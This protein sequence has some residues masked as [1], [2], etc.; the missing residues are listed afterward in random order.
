MATEPIAIVG[1]GCRFPGGAQTP[2]EYWRVL[3]AAVPTASEVP[4]ERGWSLADFHD[5]DPEAPGRTI[6]ARANFLGPVDGFDSGFFGLTPREAQAIDPQHRL[7]LEVAWEAL[8]RA[9]QSPDRL[10]G[11]RTSV[12]VGVVSRDYLD[13]QFQADPARL[14]P[15]TATGGI[16]SLLAARLSHLLDLRSLAVSVDGA[17]SS[18]LLAVHYAV[19]ALRAGEC[20][21]A[22]AG[23]VNLI[24]LPEGSVILSQMRALSPDGRSK[25]FAASADG[26]GRAEGCGIVV[27]KRLSDAQADGD[28]VLA[29]VRGSAVNQDGRSSGVTVPNRWAQQEVIRAAL[30]DGGVT[31]RAV[32]YVEVHGTGTPL[33]DPIEVA[34]LGAVLSPGR[35]PG[36]PLILGAA[37]AVVG[38]A[39][40]AA[41]AAGL[42]KAVLCLAN[43]MIPAQPDDGPLNPALDL[44][45]IPA[46]VPFTAVPWPRRAEPRFA[47]VS[48]FGFSGTNVHVVLE[49]APPEPPPADAGPQRPA[50]LLALSA[51]GE[52]P[53]RELAGRL[54]A[55]LTGQVPLADV[56]HSVNA[57]RR[58][59]PY[60]AAVTARDPGQL[61]GA[62]QA[63]AEGRQAADAVVGTAPAMPPRL[64]F[65][66]AGQGGAAVGMG[67]AL[68]ETQPTF[69]AATEELATVARDEHG[70][71]ILDVLYPRDPGRDGEPIVDTELAQPA[72]FVIEAAL[73]RLWRSWGAEPA[74]VLGHSVGEYPAACL[75]GALAWNDGLRL[76]IERG[77]LMG[78][79]P[80]GG[81]MLAVLGSAAAAAA[82]A[83]GYP[84]V[85]VAAVNGPGETVLSG[86]LADLAVIRTELARAAIACRPLRVSH[87]FHSPLMEP[88]LD[89]FEMLAATLRLR[90]PELPLVSN[91]TGEVVRPGELADGHRWRR[92]LRE[93]VLFG[94]G[95]RALLGR[96]CTVFVEIGPDAALS[97]IG[98][99][100]EPGAA[101]LP[102]LRGRRHDWDQMLDTLA[103]LYAHGVP[104]NWTEFDRDYPR[105]RRPLPTY[106]FQRRRTWLDGIGRPAAAHGG[107]P[108]RRIDSPL[109]QAQ[110][111]TVL[112]LTRQPELVDTAGLVHVGYYA[113]LLAQAGRQAGLAGR[114]V[115]TDLTISHALVLRPGTERRVQTIIEPG[116]PQAA[117]GRIASLDEGRWTTHAEATLA[118]A[119]NG[120]PPSPP[121]A[122]LTGGFPETM[123]GT[124]F[125]RRLSERRGIV[126]GPSVALIESVWRRDG[127]ALARLAAAPPSGLGFGRGVFDACVQLGYAALPAGDEDDS[128]YLLARIARLELGEPACGRLWCH[129]E[130]ATV[131]P[132]G[133]ARTGRFALTD[134]SGIVVALAEGVTLRRTR[135][136]V[137]AGLGAVPPPAGPCATDG[138]LAREV[139]ALPAAAAQDLLRQ[140][141]ADRLAQALGLPSAELPQDQP[142]TSLG[143]D[144]LMSM[145]VRN[146]LLARLGITLPLERLLDGASVGELA[147]EL[148]VATAA[149]APPPKQEVEHGVI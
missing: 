12:F 7:V 59:W 18:A 101:W 57:G 115:I 27:L 86:P 51:R 83:A 20:D 77:R 95:L 35:P 21:L 30:R 56:C 131:R 132:S 4:A 50:H 108:G 2:E 41:G 143:I 76:T 139:R 125:Y 19:R 28:T 53:L 78:S 99:R 17:C 33:G 67:R 133:S 120:P 89:E 106:P 48:A 141:L 75:A 65:L 105:R 79:L 15:Y 129:A 128:L 64:A 130:L 39:E 111:E 93:P 134:D 149:A 52:E 70:L 16:S 84:N 87:A 110:F 137:V 112:G 58:H 147:A 96:G 11:G 25:T 3:E 104:V 24:L 116:L 126:L 73:A 63:L 90:E 82:A 37:K 91:L 81:G 138:T 121:P 109:P 49:E 23:G 97:G 136:E 146:A 5:P 140:E 98:M 29:L 100:A 36:R 74:A 34:A 148:A 54:A 31:P 142:L 9:A 123:N 8:E 46:V 13:L 38:H 47:G 127:A 103:R 92:H 62:L 22:L 88:V 107:L 68:Y 60:R 6:A 144:S 85:A 43:G 10:A 118:P 1:V 117:R 113:E 45:A 135:L 42:I 124:E 119:G 122:G 40:S 102:S 71:R 72:L 94:A 61:R 44:A 66:F 145:Q 55:G 26:Y 32:D 69:R 14:T 114:A 80:A